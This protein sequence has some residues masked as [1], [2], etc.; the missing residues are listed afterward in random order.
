MKKFMRNG[1]ALI[2]AMLLIVNLLSGCGSST[3]PVTTPSPSASSGQATEVPTNKPQEIVK[4]TTVSISGGSTAIDSIT[5]GDP[6][7]T[8]YAIEKQKRLGVQIEHTM[9]NAQDYDQQMNLLIAAGEQPDFFSLPTNYPGGAS[10]AA[11][12]GIIAVI[13]E[14][15]EKNA[16]NY[17]K[18]VESNAEI[19][20][21]VKS[22]DGEVYTFSPIREDKSIVTFFGPIIRKDLLDKNGLA[23]PE[24]IDEWYTVLK[25]F[26]DSGVK[27]PFT[28]LHWFVSYSGAFVGAYGVS[29]ALSLGTDGKVH[30]GP[31]EPGFKDFLATFRQWY[32]EGLIDPD[33]VTLG[34]WGVLDTKMSSLDSAACLH[35]LSNVTKYTDNAKQK[36]PNAQFVGAPYPVLKKGDKPLYGQS[37]PLVATTSLAVVNAKSKNIEKVMEYLDYDYSP[38]GQLLANFGIEGETYTLDANGNPKYTEF[39]TTSPNAKGWTTDQTLA[40]YAPATGLAPT[41]Q[42]KSYFEQIRLTNP[43]T[44]EAVQLWSQPQLSNSLPNLTF[45]KAETM[46]TK[47]FTNIDTYRNEM[48]AKFIMGE[49]PLEKF[50]EFVQECKNLG[51]DDVLEIYNDAYARYNAR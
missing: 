20:K 48:V 29:N 27:N 32:K 38:E 8:P 43:N 33:Y 36:D 24:T 34:D 10:K 17:K 30:F 40:L 3:N 11:Q 26:K 47:K 6:N 13:S 7:K 4:L 44:K 41:V 5:G 14:T 1:S 22:D 39:V 37:D 31:I 42:L 18:L 15:W 9:T 19:A 23:V 21:G 12:D 45:T 50:D 25:T 49:E 2:L 35:F 16:P 28:A 51:I 46:V